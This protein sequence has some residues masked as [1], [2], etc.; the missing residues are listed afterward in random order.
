MLNLFVCI[1]QTFDSEETIVLDVDGANI[2]EDHAKFAINPYDEYAIEEA[3]RLREQHGGQVTVVTVGPDR[4]EKAL[5]TALAM[6][7]DQAVHVLVDRHFGDERVLSKVLASVIGP[8]EYDVILAGHV[9][10][11]SGSGQVAIRLAEE[12]G[13]VH[14]GKVTHVRIEDRHM[15]AKRDAEEATETI[16]APLPVLVTAQQGL[17]EPR[18]PSLQ[19]IM[20]AKKKPLEH[21]SISELNLDESCVPC[22]AVVDVLL[23][24]KKGKG[25]MLQGNVEEQTDELVGWLRKEMNVIQVG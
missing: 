9:A 3:V 8:R 25:R 12:L 22:T 21:W 4:A 18:Y 1:K 11:D 13:V 16:R 10:I 23:P 24:P 20:R 2:S 5:R 6:G 17:N 19:H 15:V 7:A 14:I